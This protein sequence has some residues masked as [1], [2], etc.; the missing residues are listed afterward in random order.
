MIVDRIGERAIQWSEGKNPWCRAYGLARTVLALAT[1]LTL[2]CN[3][4]ST[5]FHPIA[6]L[7]TLQTTGIPRFGFFHLFLPD[8]LE[9]ARWIAVL[10]LLV[11]ASGWRPRLTCLVHWW[12]T[13]SF[14][15]NASVVDGG[16]QVAAILTFLL[17][18]VALTDRRAWHWQATATSARRSPVLIHVVALVALLTIRIQVAGVYFHAAIGKFGVDEWVNGTALYYWALHPFFGASHWLRP[19]VELFL[20]SAA[21][22]ALVTWAVLFLEYV[23]SA[24]L[25]ISQRHWRPLLL[26]GLGL[27]ASIAVLHGLVS[28]SIIM[29]AALIL[30]LQPIPRTDPEVATVDVTRGGVSS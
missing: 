10:L 14:Q 27:H 22:V 18:P 21:S 26:M 6:G 23:L 12:I 19:S 5:L 24:A 28:F 16:D 25:L 2:L 13:V 20:V 17:L 7:S 8:H 9:Y 30:Y 3:H 11:V 29:A 1:A 15:M 4:S